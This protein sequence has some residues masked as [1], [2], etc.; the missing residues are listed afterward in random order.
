MSHAGSIKKDYGIRA[1]KHNK[2]KNALLDE[3]TGLRLENSELLT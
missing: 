3:K 1:L 2:E